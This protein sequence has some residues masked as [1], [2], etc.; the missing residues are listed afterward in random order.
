MNYRVFLNEYIKFIEFKTFYQLR[1]FIALVTV[2][3]CNIKL[4]I[5]LK[6]YFR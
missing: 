3:A 4:N 5:F 6:I 1:F 2:A